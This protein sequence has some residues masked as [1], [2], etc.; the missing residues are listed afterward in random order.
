VVNG[1][2]D[3]P[4][5]WD[6]FRFHAR[7][8]DEIVAEVHARRLGSP[9]DSV[10]KITDAA[11][12][13]LAVSDDHV[14]KGAG[15]VTHH[16][17]SL[18]AVAMPASGDYLLWLG[19][20][21]HK[22]GKAYGYRLRV[23]RRR[24]DFDL[25]VVPSAISV[26]GGTTVPVTVYAL[27]KDGFSGD[28]RLRLAD[29]PEGF[30]LSG[31]WVPAGRDKIRMTLTLPSKPEERLTHLGLEGCATVDG[32]EICRPAVPADDMMQ[33]FIYR[34][35]VPAESWTVAIETVRW[36]RPQ[37]TV[38]GEPPVKL[39]SGETTS[40]RVR[41]PGRL[42]KGQFQLELNDPPE[43]IAIEKVTPVRGGIDV[44]FRVDSDKVAA[45]LKGNLIINIFVKREMPKKEGQTKAQVRRVPLGALPAVPFEIVSG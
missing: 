8:G 9:L 42:P 22:G 5:D 19:D 40:V 13:T 28:I 43:G 20:V 12:R 45:S 24:P 7:D 26:R 15:L 38:A 16:A 14:D 10:L 33:A 1:R 31:N 3:R 34:H 6:V 4:G 41:V 32:R 36:N 11:G 44:M 27:R 21:Q 37:W 17:D 25:R 30:K 2:I 39:A 35:L 29:A 18:L 23:S